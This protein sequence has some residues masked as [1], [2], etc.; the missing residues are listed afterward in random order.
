MGREDL[1]ALERDY[2][3]VGAES[4]ADQERLRIGLYPMGFG[5]YLGVHLF[6]I[7]EASKSNE[8]HQ[9]IPLISFLQAHSPNPVQIQKM[10]GNRA[11]LNPSFDIFARISVYC[12]I[13]LLTQNCLLPNH[14]KDDP[15]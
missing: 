6:A 9:T 2:E 13:V 1:A 14:K 5:S 15:M 11:P 4:F 3:E 7:L 8:C 12:L 10:N